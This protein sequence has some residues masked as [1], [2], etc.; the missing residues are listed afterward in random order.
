MSASCL[1]CMISSIAKAVQSNP[2]V[3][4]HNIQPKIHPYGFRKLFQRARGFSLTKAASMRGWVGHVFL[5]GS[6]GW[7]LFVNNFRII[8]GL[9]GL[10]AYQ[11]EE[12][13]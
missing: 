8:Y 10:H 12:V 5:P 2:L 13:Q 6:L 3:A 1:I 9:L 7:V 4:E 11:N